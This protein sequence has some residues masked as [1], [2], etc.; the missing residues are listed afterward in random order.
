MGVGEDGGREEG[1]EELVGLGGIGNMNV[2]GGGDGNESR[3]GWEV[4]LE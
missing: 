2:I 3:V 1:I 4:G